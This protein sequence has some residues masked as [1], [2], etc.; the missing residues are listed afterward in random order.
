MA[1]VRGQVQVRPGAWVTGTWRVGPLRSGQVKQRASKGREGSPEVA[2]RW[3]REVC[4]REQDVTLTKKKTPAS[5]HT[6]D[7]QH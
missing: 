7:S 2:V 1:R 4:Q 3:Q 6:P 5:A